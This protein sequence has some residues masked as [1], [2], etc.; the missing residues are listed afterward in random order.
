M[1]NNILYLQE[2]SDLIVVMMAMKNTCIDGNG[3][4][5]KMMDEEF[6][7]RQHTF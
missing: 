6:S 4:L 3:K 7:S 5:R 1:N 2:K